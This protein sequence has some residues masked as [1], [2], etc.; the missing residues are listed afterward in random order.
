[1]V[2]YV[3]NRDER[4]RDRH[5]LVHARNVDFSDIILISLEVSYL[6]EIINHAFYLEKLFAII[7][8]KRVA[9]HKPT[10][11]IF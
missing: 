9:T 7:S 11:Q 1:M 6:L 5:T 8:I 3:V 4:D 10:K 2:L